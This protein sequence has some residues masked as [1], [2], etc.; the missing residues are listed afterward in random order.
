MPG[1][2]GSRYHGRI[3]T[4]TPNTLSLDALDSRLSVPTRQLAEPGPDETALLRIL[5]SAVRVPDHGKRVPFR[6]L[7]IA[8]G[9]REALA[10]AA[11]LRL[12]EREPNPSEGAVDKLRSRFLLFQHYAA[13]IVERDSAPRAQLE[14]AEVPGVVS[15]SRDAKVAAIPMAARF[16]VDSWFYDN[17][18]PAAILPLADWNAGEGPDVGF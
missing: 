17:G 5:R 2:A 18:L 3:M 16:A 6:F 9:A 10:D 8:G 12:R 7:R 15:D 14:V 13:Q 1:I 11:S 4:S